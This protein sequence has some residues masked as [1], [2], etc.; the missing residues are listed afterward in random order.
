MKLAEFS[1]FCVCFIEI[2]RIFKGPEKPQWGV[3]NYVYTFSH[4][5]MFNIPK[6]FNYDM[7]YSIGTFR[8]EDEDNYEFEFSVVNMRIRFG[9]RHFSKCACSEQKTRTRSRPSPPI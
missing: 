7:E 8:S 2:F 1:R 5:Q 6:T 3:A 4:I 9:G